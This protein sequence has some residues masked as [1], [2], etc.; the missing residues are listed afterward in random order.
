MVKQASKHAQKLHAR[1]EDLSRI[2]LFLVAVAVAEPPP[3]Q[4]P[5]VVWKNL[6]AKTAT[7]SKATTEVDDGGSDD[8]LNEAAAPKNTLEPPSPEEL[9]SAGEGEEFAPGMAK[10]RDAFVKANQNPEDGNLKSLKDW[11]FM[12]TVGKDASNAFYFGRNPDDAAV[13]TNKAGALAPGH[14]EDDEAALAAVPDAG[15]NTQKQRFAMAMCK[16]VQFNQP[17]YA[18]SCS[19][20]QFVLD[21]LVQRTITCRCFKSE[22]DSFNY[23]NCRAMKAELTRAYAK[24]GAATTVDQQ[25]VGRCRLDLPLTPPV[26]PVPEQATGGRDANVAARRRRQAVL[27]MHEA[28][29]LPGHDAGQPPGRR[30]AHRHYRDGGRD[31]KQLGLCSLGLGGTLFTNL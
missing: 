4:G 10:V 22:L 11:D 27:G 25:T 20:C 15:G 16:Q 28:R 18:N 9:P 21:A 26:R 6:F 14:S 31:M 17:D 5:P 29:L 3:R 30:V 7:V 8:F 13:A 2:T 1:T 24:S 12:P 19:M 23:R